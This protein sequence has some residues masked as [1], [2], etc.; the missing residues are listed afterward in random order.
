VYCNTMVL[1][2][3]CV[4]ARNAS[5]RC[6]IH[7]RELLSADPYLLNTLGCTLE[8]AIDHVIDNAD[9]VIAN[10]SVTAESFNAA[11]QLEIIPNYVNHE[12]FA[13]APRDYTQIDQLTVSM[14]SSNTTKKGIDDF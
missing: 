9:V 8:Q 11:K 4:A 7:V 14:V 2:E 1:F 10:S 12:C 3:P 13:V 5:V 6:S